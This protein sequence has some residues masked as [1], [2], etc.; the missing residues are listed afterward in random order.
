MRTAT[1]H[2]HTIVHG[3]SISFAA[4]ALAL[5]TACGDGSDVAASDTPSPVTP[6]AVVPESS[7]VGAGT[8]TV[9][10]STVSYE[11]AEST[12]TA[13]RFGEAT[14]MFEA[15]VQRKPENPWGHYM[16]GLS[17]WKSGDLDRARLAL[18]RTHEHD[19]SHEKSL[20][21]H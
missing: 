15:Y 19:P 14:E 9:D 12:Y 1:I 2:H 6:V 16:L 18:E 8:V 21:N 20:I 4:L 13:R 11:T 5:T 3:A 10:Y 7:G 17:A